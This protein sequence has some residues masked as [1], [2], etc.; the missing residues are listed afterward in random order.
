MPKPSKTKVLIRGLHDLL[1]IKPDIDEKDEKN[2]IYRS[3]C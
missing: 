3:L 2:F 1:S